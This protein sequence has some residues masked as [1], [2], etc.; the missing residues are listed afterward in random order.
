[1]GNQ[2]QKQEDKDMGKEQANIMI[3][4]AKLLQEESLISEEEQRKA[5]QMIE[6]QMLKE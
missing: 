4:I 5:V 1:M 6:S 2:K 3:N